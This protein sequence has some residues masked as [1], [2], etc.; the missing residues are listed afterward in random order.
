MSRVERSDFRLPVFVI[1]TPIKA[2]LRRP[3]ESALAAA[4]RMVER[5]IQAATGSRRMPNAGWWISMRDGTTKSHQGQILLQTI[6]GGPPDDPPG[7]EVYDDS[8]I[9]PALGCPDI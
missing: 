2:V 5:G 9:E 7:I 8:E 1:Y 3:V 4:I 6:T